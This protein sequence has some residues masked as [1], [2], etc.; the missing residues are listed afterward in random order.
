MSCAVL[1]PDHAPRPQ[2]L[3]HAL[4]AHGPSPR[5]D[6]QIPPSPESS[7]PSDRPLRGRLLS[8]T[9]LLISL[10]CCTLHKSLTQASAQNKTELVSV[11]QSRL[12]ESSSGFRKSR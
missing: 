9:L 7:Y 5:P 4:P 6:P 11:M 8:L 1:S 12:A 10:P 2:H 3:R